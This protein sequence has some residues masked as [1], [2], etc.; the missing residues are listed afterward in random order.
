MK[1]IDSQLIVLYK[2][3]DNADVRQYSAIR[4]DRKG[5]ATYCKKTGSYSYEGDDLQHFTDFVKDTLVTSVLKNK[6]LPPKIVHGFG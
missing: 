3:V 4:G 2:I 1:K 5:I 6:D